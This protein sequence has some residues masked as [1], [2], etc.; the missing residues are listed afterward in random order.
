MAF[1]SPICFFTA[2]VCFLPLNGFIN[3]AIAPPFFAPSNIFFL[4][5]GSVSNNIR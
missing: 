3:A 2:Y 4:K 1:F 5:T